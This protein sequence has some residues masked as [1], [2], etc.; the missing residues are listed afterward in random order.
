MIR[1]TVLCALLTL[2]ILA[3]CKNA[4]DV[5]LLDARAS[6]DTVNIQ[7][8]LKRGAN[9]NTRDADHGGTPIIVAIWQGHFDAVA[10]LIRE[11]ADQDLA[12][13]GGTP[14]YWAA[15]GGRNE[16]FD[17]LAARDARLDAGKE[18][19]SYLLRVVQ[20]RGPSD[21]MAKVRERAQIEGLH[22]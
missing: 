19:F 4:S 20:G 9:P 8:A 7:A 21:M 1:L 3:G 10:L 11:G 22:N 13:A 2:A 6:G 18:S 15:F 5:D 12:G 16:I 17:Y 14:L